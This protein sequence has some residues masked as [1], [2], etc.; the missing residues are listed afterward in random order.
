LEQQLAL[1]RGR[2]EMLLIEVEVDADPLEVLDRVKQ[3]DQGPSQP[4][5]RPGQTT[6]NRRRPASLSMLC[7][8]FFK[9][10][11]SSKQNWKCLG[12]PVC[13]SK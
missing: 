9:D 13:L 8:L 4:V 2:V 5:D 10:I 11:H 6:S 1:W 7:R 3:V 12:G